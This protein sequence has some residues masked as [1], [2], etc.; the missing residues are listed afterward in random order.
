MKTKVITP[1]G[2]KRGKTRVREVTIGFRFASNFV[3]SFLTNRGVQ[4]TS[5]RIAQ[6][7]L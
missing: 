5:N 6:D 4:Q 3:T 7:S 1:V 2:H